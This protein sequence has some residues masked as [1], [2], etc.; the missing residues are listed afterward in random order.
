MRG[1]HQQS[2]P[3]SG[4]VDQVVPGLQGTP[5][6]PRLSTG[7]AAPPSRITRHGPEPNIVSSHPIL[8]SSNVGEKEY[9]TGQ[10]GDGH[11]ARA[12]AHG[13]GGPPHVFDSWPQ[14][15]PSLRTSSRLLLLTDFDGTLTPLRN[16]PG[17]VPP[18]DPA[19]QGVLRRLSQHPR[20]SLY[21]I[22]GRRLSDLHKLIPVPGVRVL[23]LHG[24]EGRDVPPWKK[25][26]S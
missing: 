1:A 5:G 11:L 24:W 16:R 9:G 4:A 23:G 10:F 25:S 7:A 15:A 18:L 14:I 21:V 3:G 19:R 8:L 26:E 17:D 12:S 13:S 20:V 22:S 6:L 2:P